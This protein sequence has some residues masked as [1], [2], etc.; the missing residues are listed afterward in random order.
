[1]VTAVTAVAA[2]AAAVACNTKTNE[3]NREEYKATT[4]ITPPNKEEDEVEE[5]NP[6]CVSLPHNT[7]AMFRPFDLYFISY[8]DGNVQVE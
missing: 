5:I 6:K 7:Y 3:S 2:A 4:T 1:M 8:I